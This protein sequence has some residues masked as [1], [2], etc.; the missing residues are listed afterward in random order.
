MADAILFKIT[1]AANKASMS[2]SAMAP[3]SRKLA[4]DSAFMI[5][6]R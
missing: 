1:Q 4:N 3:L 2:N 6:E 5:K